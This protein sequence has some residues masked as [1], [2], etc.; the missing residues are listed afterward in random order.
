MDEA[1]T[2]PLAVPIT[3]AARLGGIGRSTI[4]AEISKGNLKI[5]KVGRRTIVAMEDLRA[6]LA[7]KEESAA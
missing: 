7:S 2:E 3:E 5:R 1:M 6:W 4:Y